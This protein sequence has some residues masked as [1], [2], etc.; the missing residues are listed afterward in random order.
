MPASQ[1]EQFGD[2][3]KTVLANFGEPNYTDLMVD[4]VDFPAAKRLVKANSMTIKTGKSCDWRLKMNHG[5]GAQNIAITDHDQINIVDGFVEASVN[6]RKS[7]TSYAFYEEEMSMNK[8]PKRIV[9]LIKSR[10]DS[11]MVSW[12]EKLEQNFWGFPSASDVRTP[13]G[14][15]YWVTKNATIGFTGGIPSGYS[16]VAGLSPTAYP[17]WNNYAGGYTAVTMD[18]LVR[19]ART[20]GVATGFKPAVETPSLGT[21]TKLFYGANL[22]VIQRFEDLVDTRNDNL[23]MD[24][25]KND[26]GTVFRKV[27]VTYVPFLDADT[28][29]PFYQL[30]F[31]WFHVAVLSGWWQKRTVLSPYPGQR[32]IVAVFLDSI[33]QFI[34][35]NRRVHGVLSTGTTYPT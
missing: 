11:A 21:G 14:V 18:D 19:K 12:I 28:T 5:D 32:N 15:P 10:E 1:I 8:S 13:F 23:G 3:L 30:D 17:R 6:W 24:L 34:A 26:G 20:M 29:D 33:Y 16:S 25:A 7:V 27:P 2:L 4:Q 35:H 9:D 31:G 22:T